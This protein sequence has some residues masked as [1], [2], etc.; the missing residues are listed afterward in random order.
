MPKKAIAGKGVRRIA[1][2]MN[3]DEIAM[4]DEAVRRLAEQRPGERVTRSDVLRMAALAL[5][6]EINSG[7]VKR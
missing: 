5:A 3:K 4:I 6:E 1:V 7:K 2:A